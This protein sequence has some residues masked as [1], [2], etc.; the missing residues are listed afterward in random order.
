[1]KTWPALAIRFA[2]GGLWSEDAVRDLLLA[3]LNDARATAVQELGERWLAFFQTSADRDQAARALRASAPGVGLVE[4]IEIPD[5]DWARRSQSGLA[6]IRVGRIVVTPPWA[7]ARTD[8][9]VGRIT[10]VIQPSMGFGT[11]HHATTRLC[12]ELLQGLDLGGRS[13]L[14]V[15]TGSGVLALAARALGARAVTAVDDDADAIESARENLARNGAPG[16]I[17]LVR[18]DFRAVLRAGEGWDVVTANL[19]GGLL[20]RGAGTLSAAVAAGGALVVSGLTRE[21]EAD[22]M[23]AFSPGMMPALRLA[24]DEWVGVVLRAATGWRLTNVDRD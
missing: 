19:T 23:A 20:I 6:P 12:L 16:G 13:A 11:G 15:G 8:A 17:D 14:D 5:E 9:A 3:A 10:I 21:E 7:E 1:M 2:A 24:E 4:P 22:V 18:G